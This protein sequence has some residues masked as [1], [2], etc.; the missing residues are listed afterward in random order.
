MTINDKRV[1]E[2]AHLARL[3]FN[4]EQK[5]AIKK[6]LEK[7]IDFC[8]QLKELDTEGVEPLIYVNDEFNVFREDKIEASLPKEKALLNAPSKDSD[9]FK[10]PKV[11]NK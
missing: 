5:A 9:Y 6:D 3:E 4:S 2:L 7:I 8:D 1:E 11:L 10:V